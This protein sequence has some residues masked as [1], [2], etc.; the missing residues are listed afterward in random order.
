MKIF[1]LSLDKLIENGLILTEKFFIKR[2]SQSKFNLFLFIYLEK[3]SFLFEFI[4]L[5]IECVKWQVLASKNNSMLYALP[6]V[7]LSIGP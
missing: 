4:Y 5:E 6:L 7:K 2:F 3:L 1:F